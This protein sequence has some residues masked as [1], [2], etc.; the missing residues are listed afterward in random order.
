MDEFT[1]LARELVLTHKGSF[2]GLI[3]H[4]TVLDILPLETF[5]AWFLDQPPNN[6]ETNSFRSPGGAKGLDVLGD[7]G[8]ARGWDRNGESILLQWEDSSLGPRK[9]R[10]VRT[11]AGQ[12]A[13]VLGSWGATVRDH[14][15]GQR[16][17]LATFSHSVRP[18]CSQ[19]SEVR[20][21]QNHKEC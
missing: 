2:L 8:P 10:R 16:D 12:E 14:E 18:A 20:N 7:H 19:A 17:S 3:G 21:S 4:G 9:E 15:Q 13:D 6:A 11:P 1:R 5:R